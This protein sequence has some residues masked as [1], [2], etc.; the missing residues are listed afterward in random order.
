MQM[1]CISY[2][3][4]RYI[5]ICIYTYKY[6]YIYIYMYTHIYT[7]SW[8]MSLIYQIKPDVYAA[9]SLCTVK[10]IIKYWRCWI[11]KYYKMNVST[12]MISHPQLLFHY[13]SGSSTEPAAHRTSGPHEQRLCWT[14]ETHSD[15]VS[16]CPTRLPGLWRWRRCFCLKEL[17]HSYL[18]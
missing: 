11:I 5:Y 7:Y 16:D 4:T 1:I 18:F 10:Q 12:T 13:V 15:T 17:I 2:F 8:Q 9:F 14:P 3:D 6:I